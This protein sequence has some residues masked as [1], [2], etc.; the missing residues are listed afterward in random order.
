MTKKKRSQLLR[1][2]TIRQILITSLL[3]VLVFPLA[4]GAQTKPAATFSDFGQWET[5]GRAGSYGGFSPDGQW[6]A[7][8]INRTNGNNELRITKLGD[9]KTE[10]VVFATQP[11]FS[12]NSQ[13][14]A[15][16]IGYSEAEQ[17]KMRTAKKS[18]QNKLGLMNLTTSEMSTIDSIQSFSFSSDGAYL[19]MKRYRPDGVS[20]TST[21]SK[22]PLG[23]TLIIRQLS[24]GRDIMFGNVSQNVWQ[25][26]DFSHMLAMTISADGK[27]GN[28]VH[29]F[30][31]E[32]TVLRVL[33]SSSSTYTG[34]VWRKDA[35]DLAVFR[36]ETNE[37]KE[38]STHVVLTW[39][40]LDKS[41]REF[42]YDPASDSTFPKGMRIVS[43][44]ALSW[45][46]DG[47]VLF[48][49][50]AP[51]EEKIVPPEKGKK[52]NS[53][54]DVE[55]PST[56]EIWHWKDVFVMPWQKVHA[57]EDRQRN[58]L[59]AWHIN[60]GR[61]V[62]LSKDLI[63][64]RI[65]PIYH[66]NL[67][68]VVEWLKYAMERSI[69][70]TGADL[71]LQD[72]LT[73]ERT[74]IRENINDRYIR[75][76]ASGKY[77][78]FLENNHYWTV[79]LTTHKI[80]NITKNAPV[81]FINFESDSTAKVYPDKLQKPPFG[82]GGWTRSDE[83][84]LLYDKYDLW[85][86]AVDG[87][88]VNR[89]TDG[90]DEQV[91]HRFVRLDQAGSMGM[92]GRGSSAPEKWIDLSKPVYLS[93]YGEWTKKSGYG[94]LK[95]NGSVNR[96]VWLDKNVGSLAKAKEAEIYAYT[97]QDYD[98]SPDIFV[99]ATDFLDFK[100]VTQTN[101]FHSNYAW[102]TSELITY[103]TDKGRKL[104]GVLLYP[105][106]YEPGKKYPMI[107]YNYELLS[108]NVHRY[109]APS[110]RSYYNLSVFTSLGYIVLEPDIV[111]RKRQPGWSVVEC[112]TAGVKKVIE[113]GIVDPERIGIIGHSMGGFNTSFVATHTDGIF[114]AAVAGAPITDQVSYYGD[115]HWG[116]GIAETDHIETGQER[117]EV[118][119]YEDLQAYID[120]SAV[121]NVHNMTVPLLLEAGDQDGIIAWYQSIELYNIARRAKKNVVMLGYIGEDHGLRQKQNQRDYQRRIL[122]WFGH[123][124]KGEP[125]E[126]W[127]TEGQSF[128]ERETEKKQLAVRKK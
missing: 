104:Q 96:L 40:G 59:S 54:T 8:G 122:A 38:G 82:V 88:R 68:Y 70:R 118:A 37:K 101:P 20:G 21:D 31:P 22:E 4:L 15:Y 12:S 113:M 106:G 30:D 105:A 120:N 89:L 45:S 32:T 29:L 125:A 5:L 55:D 44:R 23:T 39:T 91:R 84:V 17:E 121:Y 93:L 43:F 61:F 58:L 74:K 109:T 65:V 123:Y 7:Y 128:L 71:Y 119:L 78:L 116:S 16:R 36:A 62:Q 27:A 25:D 102:G 35:A 33:D 1:G 94:Q 9:G 114:A 92:R 110:D 81:S 47:K 103:T 75:A 79:D 66:T 112:V 11:V 67:A 19:A 69:G 64:E 108:Q 77:L 34:L 76:G 41:E 73:G 90:A 87:S 3:Y 95:P 80:T 124:L 26:A 50:I 53:E 46:D 98:D 126:S 63:T 56:V 49:G 100:Q 107:V 14:I 60:S 52:E 72:I 115:H 127:I 111:F 28:G 2:S 18:V 83:A 6:L 86:V 48:L 85:Q 99:G 42:F 97:A 13:W 10:V 57:N 117:M 24:S 51:W